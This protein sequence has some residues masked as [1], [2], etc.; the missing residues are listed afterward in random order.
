MPLYLSSIVRTELTY[1]AKL[2]NLAGIHQRSGK[3]IKWD[4][5]RGL[6]AAGSFHEN[7]KNPSKV[8]QNLKWG[9]KEGNIGAIIRKW[10]ILEENFGENGEYAKK[11]SRL[12]PSIQ[13]RWQKV[14]SWKMA[15]L[16]KLQIWQEFIGLAKIKTRWQKRH[17][18]NCGFYENDKFYEI[19]EFGFISGLA[20]VL[21][22]TT[23]EAILWFATTRQGSNV[24]D[25]YNLIFLE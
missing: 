24:G 4:N 6:L 22:E 5:K 13:I 8:L 14:A 10:Q 20:K 18:D 3:K 12:L 1:F 19:G 9:D 21:N 15:I 7:G 23:K 2:A 25:Q 11:S 16:R 17:V